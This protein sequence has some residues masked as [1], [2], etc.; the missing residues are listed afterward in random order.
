MLNDSRSRKVAVVGYNRI[1]F[2]R[3]NTAYIDASNQDMMTAALKGLIERYQLQAL[4]LGEFAGGAVIKRT[5]DFNL[6]RESLLGTSLSPSTPAADV[7]QACATGIETAIYIANKI[8][9]SQID[10]G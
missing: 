10:V 6:T 9:L 5:R 7:Q 1:P 3:A 4:R 8:S 2:A